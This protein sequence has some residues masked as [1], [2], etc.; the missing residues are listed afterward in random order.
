MFA[1]VIAVQQM[2]ES[3]AACLP[4]PVCSSFEVPL[5]REIKVLLMC[6][7]PSVDDIGGLEEKVHLNFYVSTK[8]R[9]SVLLCFADAGLHNALVSSLHTL[10][11]PC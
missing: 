9:D 8:V 10:P 4:R 3:A 5:S 1:E 7:I 2:L 11:Q 6:N